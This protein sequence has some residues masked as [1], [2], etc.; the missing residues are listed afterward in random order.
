MLARPPAQVTVL[1]IISAVD[2]LK[3]ITIC[4]LGKSSQCREVCLVH[5]KIDEAI[6][7]VERIF[8]GAT[9]SQ[10]IKTPARRPAAHAR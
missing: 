2:P 10:L 6:A 3:R 5:R 4:P 8:S 7:A 1:D 9:L